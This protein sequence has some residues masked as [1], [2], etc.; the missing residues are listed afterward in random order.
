M[1]DAVNLGK[2]V[3]T[4]QE[5]VVSLFQ[6]VKELNRIRQKE[7]KNVREYRWHLMLA[8][9]PNDEKNIKLSY[10]DRVEETDAIVDD[11][12]LSVHKPEFQIGRA[13]V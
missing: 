6:Y 3:L 12:I 13:H 11:I 9:I 1:S 7:V 5:K 4:E 10:R 8:D 2:E